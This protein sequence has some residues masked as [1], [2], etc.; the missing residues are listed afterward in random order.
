M[1]E[2]RREVTAEAMSAFS[3]L[4]DP[5]PVP[6]KALRVRLAAPDSNSYRCWRRCQEGGKEA[7]PPEIYTAL[8]GWVPR[9]PSALVPSSQL[10]LA[11]HE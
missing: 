10:S 6:Q 7:A 5:Q 2:R 3:E 1:A 11:F 8:T 4:S 9:S